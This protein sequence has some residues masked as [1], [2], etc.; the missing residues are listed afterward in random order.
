MNKKNILRWSFWPIFI[1]LLIVGYFIFTKKPDNSHLELIP[2]DVSAV[3]IVDSKKILN[4]YYQLLRY[5]P[6]EIDK[7]LP[8]GEGEFELP[9]ELPGISPLNKVALYVYQDMETKD[10]QYF[11]SM[12]VSV[13]DKIAFLKT[14]NALKEKP[15]KKEHGNINVFHFKKDNKSLIL[16]DNVGI[17]IEPLNP[18]FEMDIE[19]GQRHYEMVYGKDASRLN[20]ASN[21]FADVLTTDKQMNIW[22]S[23]GEGV[24][25]GMGGDQMGIN[26]L[27]NSQSIWI[28][29][30][31][32]GIETHALMYL[33]DKSLLV[34][35]ETGEAELGEH[36]LLKTS[37]SVNPEKFDEYFH[38]LLPADQTHITDSWT[39]KL[40]ASIIGFRKKPVYQVITTY[41]FDEETF[42]TYAVIDTVELSKRVNLP[43]FITSIEVEKPNE[44]LELIKNDSSIIQENGFWKLTVPN[45]LDEY[46][47]LKVEESNLIV[48]SIPYKFEYNPTYKT[49]AF[50]MNIQRL[51]T[52]YP[53]KDMLQAIVI[54]S[55][56]KFEFKSF[57]MHHD[58]IT[59]EYLI[60]HGQLKM[61]EENVHTLL[62]IIPFVYN[63]VI[64]F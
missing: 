56:H 18:S 62:Q 15:T 41:E 20:E 63:M 12:I 9:T 50:S 26:K 23:S 2:K 55:L 61:G 45:L 32:K 43:N 27:F 53:P 39:G 7:V 8:D 44:V 16:S 19:I 29:L 25:Q 49:F 28:N 5:N 42:E 17:V 46:I 33:N 54:P 11:K 48:S 31:Q 38:N 13:D 36:E 57:E 34:E 37:M 6:N 58:G 60:L 24:L 52:D 22:V 3:V 51:I 47:Y 30:E 40:C 21:S 35:T 1:L 59:D 64:D 14:T 4:D 10:E